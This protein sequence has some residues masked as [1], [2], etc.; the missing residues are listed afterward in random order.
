MLS[1]DKQFY[2]SM[3]SCLA[4]ISAIKNLNT[5]FKIKW[6]NDIYFENKKLGGILIENI[7][8]GFNIYKTIIGIGLNI[9]QKQFSTNLPNP[10]SLF[11]ICNQE[12]DKN[13]ILN[14]LTINLN[15]YLIKVVA[16]EF[17]CLKTE[18][19]ENLYLFNKISNFKT[20]SE[21][22]EGKIIDIEDFGYLVIET[23][24]RKILKFA[25]KEVDFI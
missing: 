7:L 2:I 3:A 5:N 16:N 14:Q 4:I 22:I 6:P 11:Q 23:S 13:L 17:D 21:I 15:K 19:I 24:N 12:F 20:K 8:H 1:A 25:F 18:Y 9:N 10:V